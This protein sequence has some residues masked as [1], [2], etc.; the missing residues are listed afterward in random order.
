M[1]TPPSSTRQHLRSKE[2]PPLRGRSR[3]N[4]RARLLAGN[5]ARLVTLV[6][7]VVGTGA[8]AGLALGYPL[9]SLDLGGSDAVTLDQEALVGLDAEQALVAIDDLPSSYT[10]ADP[11]LAAGIALI[12]A[13][14][15]GVTATPEAAVGEPLARAF[16]DTTNNALMLTEVVRVR[17]P[18]DAGKYIKE[19]TRVFDG[20][21]GQK[22]FTG[23]GADKEQFR[24]TNPRKD[25]PLELDYLTRTLT[26]VDGGSV[27]IVTY[28]QVG[29]VIVSLQYA[30]PRS[31]RKDLM[32][33]AEDEILY[34]VAP[35]Q[36]SK[37]AKVK[38][39]K[40]IPA[41]TTTTVPD[42]VQPSPTSSPPTV[43]PPPPTFDPP[44]TTRAP[45]SSSRATTTVPPA[46]P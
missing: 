7:L 27:R 14:Y 32:N 21:T 9:R 40:P 38:G 30:G 33:K 31:P 28:F 4:R 6:A 29:N 25:P 5:A 42:M 3:A 23:S 41:E 10:D 1:A 39:S 12:G 26:P 45:R 11:S 15:C 34:R 19:L 2:S 37:T 8:L 17:Q 35:D 22:Y 43:A 18:N 36:F 24:I 44:T 46:G 16:V 13:T 20:C